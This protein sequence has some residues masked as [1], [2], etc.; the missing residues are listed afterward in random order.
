MLK[1]RCLYILLLLLPSFLFCQVNSDVNH[2]ESD[3]CGPPPD[4]LK[5]KSFSISYVN[6]YTVPYVIANNESFSFHYETGLSD[7]NQIIVKS[8]YFHDL[9]QNGIP[10]DSLVLH[11]DGLGADLIA[12][13][14][15]FSTG[16]LTLTRTAIYTNGWFS[17][18]SDLTFVFNDGTSYYENIDLGFGIRI[19][20]TDSIEIPDVI[21]VNDSMQK[22][23]HNVNIIRDSWSGMHEICKKY[24]DVFPDDRQIIMFAT[25]YPTP[26]G[27]AA[28]YGSVS[29]LE[30]GVRYDS[31]LV[32]YSSY[33][34]SDSVLLGIMTHYYTYGGHVIVHEM[35]HHWAAFLN[36]ILKLSIPGGH[37]GVI[38]VESSGFGGGWQVSY[39]NQVNDTLFAAAWGATF[40]QHYN[41]LE[42]YLMG[43]SALDSINFPIETLADFEFQGWVDGEMWH[44]SHTG[45]LEITRSM[46]VDAM[47]PRVPDYLN[48]RKL[49]K[50]AQII[51]SDRFLTAKEMAYY[52]HEMKQAEMPIGDPNRENW[53]YRN[54]NFQE[55]TY[56]KAMFESVL[57]ALCAELVTD[58]LLVRSI[59]HGNSVQIGDSSFSESGFYTVILDNYLGCDSLVNL[60]LEVNSIPSIYLGSDKIITTHDTLFLSSNDI[61]SSY[62]WS[63]G[64][65]TK[66]IQIPADLLGIGE[67]TY[68]LQVTNSEGCINS[69]TIRINVIEAPQVILDNLSEG[70][71]RIYP[72][73]TSGTLNIEITEISSRIKLVIL[74]LDGSTL[75]SKTY[76]NGIFISDEIELSSFMSGYYLISIQTK[77]VSS[78]NSFIL[79]K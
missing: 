45:L 42:Q 79:S 71:V 72:N 63:N 14:N 57:P 12:G 54:L 52:D 64:D 68:W 16:N 44:K 7:V 60:S 36:P 29:R 20:N 38:E 77:D 59:C 61:F 43:L 27:P 65:T 11:D 78:I 9:W 3:L 35:L 47:A 37:W 21:Q 62:L 51:I 30:E 67:F 31:P 25:T 74:S 70:V 18:F 15:I 6:G 48:S 33:Y 13:D 69:D 34:G 2:G 46:Y 26:G 19:I 75:Y 39:I 23:T 24:Y 66:S 4:S 10:V 22:T 50:A 49:F 8:G 17:R 56:G 58:T 53:E 55:A 32:D 76:R 41:K 28:S 1:L 40:T 73:P 5:F